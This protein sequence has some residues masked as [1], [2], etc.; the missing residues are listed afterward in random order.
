MQEFAAGLDRV[1]V[2]EEKRD[3]LEQQ[4]RSALQ[5]LGRPIQVVGKRDERGAPCSPSRAGWTP[6]R[7]PSAWSRC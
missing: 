4:V 3:F 1:V 5:P 2:V 6:T 7:W